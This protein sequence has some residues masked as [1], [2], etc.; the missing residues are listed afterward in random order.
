[1]GVGLRVRERG[2]GGGGSERHNEREHGIIGLTQSVAAENVGNIRVNAVAPGLV[3]T[4]LTWNQ[5][6]TMRD[7]TA[8]SY[9]GVWIYDKNDMEYLECFAPLKPSIEAGLPGHTMV[10]PYDIADTVIFLMSDNAA[11]ISGTTVSVDNTASAT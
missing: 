1:M 6:K 7:P 4:P 2:E 11:M 5:C 8:Q 9:D 3:D 10:S